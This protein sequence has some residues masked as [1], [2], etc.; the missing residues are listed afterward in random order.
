[1]AKEFGG[2]GHL[3]AAGAFVE[4][5][6]ITELAKEVTLKAKKYIK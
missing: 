3:N 6:Q 2:G 1:L 4:G 5:A